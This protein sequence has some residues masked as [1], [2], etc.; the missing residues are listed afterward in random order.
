MNDD[1]YVVCGGPWPGQ[2]T[3]VRG[4]PMSGDLAQLWAEWCRSSLG[5][6]HWVERATGEDR[7]S[8]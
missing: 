1:L 3:I 6:H 2:K 5:V 7:D 4:K 8:K